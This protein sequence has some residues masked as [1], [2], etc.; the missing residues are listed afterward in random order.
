MQGHGVLE[1]AVEARDPAL[2]GDQAPGSDQIP[3]I[4]DIDLCFGTDFAKL[5]LFPS[6]C[7]RGVCRRDDGGTQMGG[8][9]IVA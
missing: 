9:L 5:A 6:E 2:S 7:M 3:E 4:F 1:Q 8:D